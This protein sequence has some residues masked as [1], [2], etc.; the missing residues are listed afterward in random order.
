MENLKIHH[1]GYLVKKIDKAIVAFQNLGYEKKTGIIFDE[2][3]GI[4]ICF[5]LKDG[6]RIELVCPKTKDSVVYGLMKK[7][8]NSPYHTCYECNRIEAAID[9]LRMQGYV[10]FDE[11]HAAVAFDDNNVC[12]MVHPYLGMIELLEVAN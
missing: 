3:R 9:D 11:P 7:I 12:F 6:Y 10:K 2:Y 1:I 5:M 8:G 4:D